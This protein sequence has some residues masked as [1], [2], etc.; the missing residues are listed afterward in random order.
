MLFERKDFRAR[1]VDRSERTR[2]HGASRA[3][4][5]D[6]F[7]EFC[8]VRC[9]VEELVLRDHV[10]LAR[11]LGF[12]QS[13]DRVHFD[14]TKIAEHVRR[15]DARK[16]GDVTS[17]T[18]YARG[19]PINRRVM[20]WRRRVTI[21][22]THGDS[23]IR[24]AHIRTA[25]CDAMIFCNVAIG[26]YES[27][28]ADRFRCHVHIERSR[29]WIRVN[30]FEIAAFVVVAAARV[31][32]TREAGRFGWFVNVGDRINQRHGHFF[33]RRRKFEC[34]ILVH[35]FAFVRV[36]LANQTIN[37]VELGLRRINTGF[38]AH[39]DMT[40][41]TTAVHDFAVEV[42]ELSDPVD[43]GVRAKVI[44]ASQFAGAIQVR[45]RGCVALPLI[46]ERAVN[47]A[48]LVGVTL[49]A[50]F[51]AFVRRKATGV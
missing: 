28:A 7:A 50:R 6:R 10:L 29:G 26:T 35:D 15:G 47:L 45:H 16:R 14:R 42:R 19:V 32:V 13:F 51:T 36:R 18:I 1:V 39:A 40:G 41:R 17:R 27:R 46:V 48:R 8:K 3:V 4:L 9:A 34:A 33:R 43:V 5:G 12:V 22:A 24:R 2:Q 38:R 49:I 30:L 44:D 25:S 21:G 23:E 31:R 11:N 37:V 20:V